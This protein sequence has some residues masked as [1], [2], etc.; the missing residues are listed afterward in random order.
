MMM[1]M[2]APAASTR[3]ALSGSWAERRVRT[4]DGNSAQEGRRRGKLLRE[5]KKR[6]NIYKYIQK[7][8]LHLL[9]AVPGAPRAVANRSRRIC[10]YVCMYAYADICVYIPLFLAPP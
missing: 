3:L 5:E 1:M 6:I 10:M 8:D 2:G 9:F 7:L 4:Q